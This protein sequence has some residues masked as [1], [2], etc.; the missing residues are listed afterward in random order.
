MP[1]Y[2][3]PRLRSRCR[4][5]GKRL[6]QALEGE[7]DDGEATF[8]RIAINPGHRALVRLSDRAVA[9]REFGDWSMGSHLIGPVVGKGRSRRACRR[10]DRLAERPEYAREPARL[11]ADQGRH[12]RLS[13]SFVLSM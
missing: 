8:S 4:I 6:L 9:S 5:D 7:L 10:D 11:R 13:S 3:T 1:H 2:R 12:C